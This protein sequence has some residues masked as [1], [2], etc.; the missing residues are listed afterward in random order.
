MTRANDLVVPSVRAVKITIDTNRES[1]MDN[2]F[3][4]NVSATI[5]ADDANSND[6][7]VG[8]SNVSAIAGFRL[9]A[10]Q[11]LSGVVISDLSRVFIVGGAAAQVVW[12]FWHEPPMTE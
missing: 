2:Q 5:K 11:A 8:G 4:P 3:T 12:V 10:G 1:L 9:D 6:V 7:F